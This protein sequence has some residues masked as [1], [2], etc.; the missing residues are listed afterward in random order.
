MSK[1]K[2]YLKRGGLG[3]LILVILLGS[4]GGFYFKSYLPNTVAPKSF[5]Q[6]DGNIQLDGLDAPVDIYRDNM[7]IPHIYAS[8]SHDL[9]FAQGYVHA[10]DRF[11]QMDFYRHVGEGRTAEMFGE[12]QVDDDKFLTTLGWRKD[13]KKEYEAFTAETKATLNAYADGVNAYL[14]D[15]N[16]EAVSLEYAI[17]KLLSPDYKIEPWSPLDTVAWSKALAWD[18]RANMDEEIQRAVLLKTLTPEQVAELF[19]PYPNDHPVIVNKIGDGSSTSAPT[20]SQAI[21]IP[22]ETLAALQHN[23]SLLDNLLGPLS[24]GVGSNS[25]VVSGSLTS[26]GKPLLANDPHLG[27]AMPSIWYQVDMHCMPQSDACPFE[28]AG[29]SLAGAPGIILGHNDHIAWGFTF[30]YEDVMDL[31]IEKVNPENPNQYEAN[32]QWVDFESHQETIN[33]VG[34]KPVEITVRSTRHGPVISNVYGPLKDQGDP[35]DKEFVP[36]KER[37]GV[38]LPDQYVIALNWAAL[39]TGNPFE[40]IFGFNKAQNWEQFRQAAAIFHTPGH[41]LTYADIDGNIGYQ[42]SGDVPI[43]KK[44]DGTVPIPGWTGEYD[45]TGYI[46]FD[47]LP[48]TFNPSEGYIVSANQKIPPSDYP[49]FLTYDWDYGFRAQRIL[50][51]LKNAPGK[52][53]IP[54]IQKMHGDDYDAS[55]TNL[56]PLLLNMGPQF[57]TPNETAAIDLLKSWDYQARAD[58][59]AAAV[60]ETFWRAFLK[61][62]FND[63]LPE[64]YWAGGG[65]RWFEVVR[66]LDANS[67]WW[68][69]KSTPNTVET[70]DE[71]MK[72]SFSEGVAELEKTLGKDPAKWNWGSLHGS[73]F[74][75]ATLGESGVAPIEALFNRG[76]FATSGGGS[77]VNA[78]SWNAVDGY[79]TTNLPSMRAIYDMSNLNNSLTVHTTGQSG[80]AYNKHYIDMA[81]LWRNIQYY[82]M[83]WDQKDVIPQAEGHLVLSP[84]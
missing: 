75:N 52:I 21:N 40:A 67:P 2:M 12:G 27:I 54:Y 69:D 7:G 60:Y 57:T 66:N 79:E 30:S 17:L 19:P 78:T 5:P 29:F 34:G 6:I 50:D 55:A 83:T 32:G 41:N 43:R 72:K 33:V 9:F 18:L 15:H 53:D 1:A 49:N 47:Q 28:F 26:T 77:I 80:H 45:W 74:R 48:Y 64:K 58:S 73:N 61:N 68:D 13:G 8:T 39:Q 4:G 44:G 59:S 3:L 42:T 22:D 62:T 31:F 76:P 37:A 25:W 63:E 56:V 24:D 70:R 10:Q 14:K 23:A 46:P 81:D 20:S 71:I 35:K 65:D 16:G 38:D 84:K 51:L 11:W 82:S 36:F